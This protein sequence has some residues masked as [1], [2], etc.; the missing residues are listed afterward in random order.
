MKSLQSF[1]NPKRKPNLKFKLP[2]F[3]E[4]FEMRFLTSD[5]LMELGKTTRMKGET[6]QLEIMARQVA[7]S[8]VTP[9]LHNKE[10]LQAL[11]ERENKT[12]LDPVEAL[13]YIVNGAE[14]AELIDIYT[15]YSDITVDFGNK[16]EEVKN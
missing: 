8:L 14:L 10:L 4:E 16:I 3:E 11:S 6:G 13:K 12:I 9:D 5:E 7:E 15:N 2:A 1:L